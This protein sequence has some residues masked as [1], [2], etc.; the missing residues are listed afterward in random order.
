VTGK[1]RNLTKDAAEKV[2]KDFLKLKVL[3]FETREDRRSLKNL[4]GFFNLLAGGSSTHRNGEIALVNCR[5]KCTEKKSF[6]Q[7]R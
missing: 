3:K 5:R 1:C 4:R 2:L 6:L 7:H